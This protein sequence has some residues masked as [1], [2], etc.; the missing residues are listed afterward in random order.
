MN[1][2]IPKRVPQLVGSTGALYN[3]SG[4]LS[5]L[6]NSENKITAISN[7]SLGPEPTEPGST[8]PSLFKSALWLVIVQ[9]YGDLLAHK[10]IGLQT[11]QA[12]SRRTQTTW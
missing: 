5:H 12:S 8:E 10:C 2:D 1:H 11:E 6:E 4:G 9:R 3:G 7:E